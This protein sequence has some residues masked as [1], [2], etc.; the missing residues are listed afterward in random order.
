VK[1]APEKAEVENFWREIY[2]NKVKHNGKACWIKKLLPTKSKH[3]YVK[4]K[5]K[6][7]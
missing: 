2:G 4:K 7:H 3:G 1:N 5:K 6:K